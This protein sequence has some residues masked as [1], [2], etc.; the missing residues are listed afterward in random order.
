MYTPG[1]SGASFQK[2]KQDLDAGAKK[3]TED[4]GKVQKDKDEIKAFTD[5][6]K[7]EKQDI[8]TRE[9]KIRQDE[10]EIRKLEPEIRTI[11][12]QQQKELMALRELERSEHERLTQHG[13][14][15]PPP[16]HS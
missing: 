15:I 14:K 13:I 2:F 3:L 9:A 8:A 11:E 10:S 5:Q 1:N 7:K 4:K 16:S 12:S 6:N